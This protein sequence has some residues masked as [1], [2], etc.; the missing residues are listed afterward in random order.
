MMKEIYQCR[1]HENFETIHINMEKPRN[2]YVPFGTEEDV[3]SDRERSSKFLLL[4]GEWK[5][6]YYNSCQELEELEKNGEGTKTASITVPGCWQLQGYDRAQYVNYRY[7][8]PFDPPYVPDDT[9]V[10]V[11]ER[12]F[13]IHSLD[14]RDYFINFE[15][16]DSCFYL[17][18]NNRFVGYSQVSHNTSEFKLTDYLTEGVNH[19]TAAVLKWCD[20]TYLECQD[21]WRLSGIFRDVYLLERPKQR[22]N[23]FQIHTSIQEASA[24]ITL[25]LR[26]APGLK[27]TLIF[28]DQ[29]NVIR[30][31]IQWKL[32]RDG[33]KEVTVQ[34]ENPILWN[35]EKPYLY[36]ITLKTDEE[37]IGEKIG[38]RRVCVEGNRFLLNGQPIRLKGVNRHDFSPER[39][40][41][42][43]K[44]EIWNDLVLM[45]KL[46][47]NAV[48]TSHYPN[49]PLMAQMCDE[50]GIYLIEEA[51]IETHGS[52]DASLCYKDDM[53]T[54]T[55]LDGMGMVVAMPEYAGQL[56]DRIE[57]MICRD[58]NRSSVLI[59]SLGNESGYSSY[60]RNAGKRAMELDPD[61]LVHYESIE[62]QYQRKETED[63]F[64]IRSRM[65]P[66]FQWMKDYG[67]TEGLRRPLV[68][69]E[70]SHAMGNGPGDLEDYW[71]IIYSRECFMGA[72]VWE[73]AEHGIYTGKG[74]NGRNIY[75]YGGDFG[76]DVHDGRYCMDG[77]VAPD[78]SLRSGSMEVK[79][80]YRPV[81]V[82]R[83]NQEQQLFEFWNTLGFTECSEL[84]ECEYI[85]EEFGRE[86]SR[87]KL[88][89][90]LEPGQ[91]KVIAL[92]ELEN[93]EGESLYIR[94][95]FRYKEETVYSQK[96]ELAGFEQFCLKKSANY[97]QIAERRQSAD[98]DK[99]LKVLE[100]TESGKYIRVT[101][102]DF[103]YTISRQTGLFDSMIWKG[104]NI[105][106]KPMNYETCRAPIDNDMGRTERWNKFY[107]D[108][109]VPKHYATRIE[110]HIRKG[111]SCL[112]TETRLSLGYAVYPPV[113]RMTVLNR[114]FEDGIFE[115]EMHVDMTDLRCAMP[116]FGIHFSL[117]KDF[118]KVQYYGYGPYESYI[119]KHQADYKSL[120]TDTVSNLFTDYSVPQETGSHYDCEYAAL[121]NGEITLEMTGTPAF[122]FQALEYTTKELTEKRHNAELE[123]SG[124]T[125]LYLD[126]RQ[127]GIGSESCCTSLKAEYEFKE[128]KF[129]FC[130]RFELQSGSAI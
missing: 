87:K 94:F 13:V 53:D 89:L 41:A 93:P 33:R 76:E 14:N 31:E 32:S 6:S 21:K 9:P 30:T 24:G 40:A 88:E 29:D 43:T 44:E 103:R 37:A 98:T 116:R 70:Y 63:I 74:E 115:I 130:W 121:S 55:D 11:Y 49:S 101:G 56:M 124:Y 75:C 25:Q 46:N 77:M 108:R 128:R 78:R 66:S 79:N 3:F 15:G 127:N 26:G 106:E 54:K 126:Y 118:T 39:G 83:I 122:S 5:F 47:I 18:V 16:V 36:R 67:E 57:T 129:D 4:N 59:W 1:Y 99:P 58:Y 71:E 34:C 112:E 60:L 117:P 119:D 50:L 28:A 52:V 109:L 23:S 102:Q 105:L 80:V 97:R 125:E 22:V 123:K 27:G 114:I 61:R 38:L 65:Y 64:P 85:L 51:D 92:P 2:Y 84:L 86:I 8:I 111:K 19:I 104:R 62:P 100:V 90:R 68:L 45:K 110:K 35:A 91:K 12:E 48:R 7:P 95:E 20:G 17:Y 120:F 96:G 69:C 107:L 82:R 73:W 113:C 81:R 10:G 72:F 42:V